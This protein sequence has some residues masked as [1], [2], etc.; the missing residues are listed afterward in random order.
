MSQRKWCLKSIPIKELSEI[1]RHIER[2]KDKM[3]EVD[4]YLERTTTVCQG[5][6]K[7]F[8]LCQKLCNKEE[9]PAQR[10]FRKNLNTEIK[11]FISQGV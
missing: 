7:M 9:S 11:P 3:L 5:L 2:A 6:E 1:F 4:P 8:A 10:T